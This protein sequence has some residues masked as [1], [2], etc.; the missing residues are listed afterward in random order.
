MKQVGT[1]NLWRWSAPV[2]NIVVGMVR[3]HLL[4]S[5]L[6]PSEQRSSEHV[7]SRAQRGASLRAS[8]SRACYHIHIIRVSI[9]RAPGPDVIAID[10]QPSSVVQNVETHPSHYLVSNMSESE[11]LPIDLGDRR[12]RVLNAQARTGPLQLRVGPGMCLATVRHTACSRTAISTNI[13]TVAVCVLYGAL[14]AALRADCGLAT[15]WATAMPRLSP[16]AP[17]CCRL[18]CSSALRKQL[19]GCRQFACD[20]EAAHR[21]CIAYEPIPPLPE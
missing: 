6:F 8:S 18:C 14:R 20:A 3:A 4:F 16:R 7:H 13:R 10:R 15:F 11:P 5:D 19:S 17:T 21:L 1:S 9:A 2:R 12:S